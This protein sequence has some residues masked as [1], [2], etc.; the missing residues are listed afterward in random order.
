ME[1]DTAK[2][3]ARALCLR[4]QYGSHED[5][6]EIAAEAMDLLAWAFDKIEVK[7]KDIDELTSALASSDKNIVITPR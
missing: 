4:N 1:L 7:S 2:E 6:K 5:Y 3:K